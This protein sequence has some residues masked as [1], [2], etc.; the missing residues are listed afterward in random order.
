MEVNMYFGEALEANSARWLSDRVG[1]HLKGLQLDGWVHHL[2]QRHAVKLREHLL[3]LVAV[4]RQE[5]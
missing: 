2:C 3:Q 1:E 5:L 4:A